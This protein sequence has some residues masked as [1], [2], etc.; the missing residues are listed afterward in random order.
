[1][2]ARDPDNQNIPLF[3]RA[4]PKIMYGNAA[5]EG[6]V[7]YKTEHNFRKASLRAP[8]RSSYVRLWDPDFCISL[9]ILLR[10]FLLSFN[11]RTFVFLHDLTRK[12]NPRDDVSFRSRIRAEFVSGGIG[13][14]IFANESIVE[15]IF[16]IWPAIRKL[17]LE[18]HFLGR[19]NLFFYAV[20]RFWRGYNRVAIVE[21]GGRTL[22]LLIE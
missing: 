2:S 1:M 14:S 10:P 4:R 13:G 12:K 3:A 20:A 11:C 5:S 17:N 9:C 8:A 19:C 18:F 16:C 6:P 22:G 7:R 15:L 21:R